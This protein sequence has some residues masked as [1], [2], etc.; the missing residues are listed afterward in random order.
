MEVGIPSLPFM[1]DG[2]KSGKDR[3]SRI[4]SAISQ[5]TPFRLRKVQPFLMLSDTSLAF[6]ADMLKIGNYLM[7]ARL[8]LHVCNYVQIHHGEMAVDV[9]VPPLVVFE[10]I[11]SSLNFLGDGGYAAHDDSGTFVT[12]NGLNYGN[13]DHNMIVPTFF[14]CNMQG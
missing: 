6:E 7:T 12:D 5:G 4:A 9:V 14:W 8:H 13:E 10:M 3:L 11:Q 1:R 2:M